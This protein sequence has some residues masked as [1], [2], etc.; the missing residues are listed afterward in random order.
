MLNTYIRRL[1]LVTWAI[2]GAALLLAAETALAQQVKVEG[3]LLQG[4]VEN[5][6]AIYWGIPYAAPPVGDLRWKAPQPAAKWQGVRAAT[7]FGRACVQQNPA[8]SNLPKPDEDCLYLNVWT[9]AK[10]AGERLPVMVWI[11]GGGFTAGT[12]GEQLYHGE[13]V[14][15]KGVVVVSIGYRLGVFGFLAH[16]ELSAENNHHVSGNYGVLDM[17]A[18][19]QWVQKNISAFGGNSSRV[20]IFGE[21]AGAMAVSLLCGSPL[22][23]GLFHGAIAQSGASFGPVHVAGGSGPGDTQTLPG[24][25]KAGAAWA[26]T[27]GASSLAE[28]RKMPA[29]KLLAS[30]LRQRGINAPVMDG[31]VY[32]DDYYKLYQAKRYSDV[33]V[34]V[35]YNSDEGATFG[36]ASSQQAYV[37]SVRQ[38]YGPFA[39]KLLAAYPGGDTPAAK[40]TGRDLTRDASFGSHSWTWARLQTQTGKSKVFLFYFDQHPDYPADSPQAGFGAAHGAECPYVFRQLTLRGRKPTPADEAL[41]DT[42]ITYWTNFA[43]TGNPNGAGL[44]QWPVY[45]EAKPLTLNIAAG[46]IQAVPPPSLDGLKVL[47]QYFAARRSGEVP[48]PPAPAP[49]PA[50]Q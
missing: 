37:D 40:K 21:S 7:D 10:S 49:P 50:R 2:S 47:D 45:S 24:A 16:P 1:A 36:V 44:P 25:E 43:R 6:L 31:W 9:P 11:H 34:I 17:I 15:K 39:D 46:N 12:P 33:P 19:L 28:L 48:P 41:S 14:A 4:T 29:D 38:R 27:V 35:G 30:S 32:A 23:K 18:G 3:G 20:T 8:I 13:W 26:S 5:G 42:I 22:A